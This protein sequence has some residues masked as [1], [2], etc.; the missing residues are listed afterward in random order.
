MDLL[1]LHALSSENNP[2]SPRGQ[3]TKKTGRGTMVTGRSFGGAPVTQSMRLAATKS[4]RGSRYLGA[5]TFLSATIFSSKPTRLELDLHIF[6]QDH[7]YSI[8]TFMLTFSV[9]SVVVYIMHCYYINGSIVRTFLTGQNYILFA[10]Q[11]FAFMRIVNLDYLPTS[12]SPL[13]TSE[14]QTVKPN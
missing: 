3:S 7:L 6:L 4:W 12:V 13:G 8:L 1:I 11:G 14:L 9:K 10:W 2:S 5:W